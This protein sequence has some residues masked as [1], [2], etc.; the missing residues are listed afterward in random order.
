MHGEITAAA[1]VCHRS[2][3]STRKTRAARS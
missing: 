1:T 2:L 3:S